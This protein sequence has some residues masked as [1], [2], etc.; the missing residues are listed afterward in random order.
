MRIVCL[1]SGNVATHMAL[2]FKST[3]AEF[4]QIWSKTLNHAEVLAVQTG[5]RATDNLKEIDRNADIYIIAVKDD[6]IA[7]IAGTLNGVAGLIVHTSGATSIDVFKSAE[8]K[9]FG[10]LYPLQTFSKSKAVDFSK[11]P[12]CIEAGTAESQVLLKGIAKAISPL[13]YEVS[14]ADRKLLHLAAVFACNFTNHL[15]HLGQE[16]LEQSQL[17]FDLL[18]PLILETAEKVQTALPY[19]VQTGPAVRDD[20]QTL[21]KHLELLQDMPELAEIYKT[22]SKSI[23]KTY[24]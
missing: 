14:S 18:R 7:E 10:V 6:A 1:G 20:K 22:L 24:L 2:A 13:I 15:Y 12:L 17:S 3:G 8:I 19:D 16:I 9:H 21:E 11:I 5:A 4:L 23:K